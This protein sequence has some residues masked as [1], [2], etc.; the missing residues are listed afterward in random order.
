MSN[1]GSRFLIKLFELPH[2][3]YLVKMGLGC[4]NLGFVSDLSEK[5]RGFFTSMSMYDVSFV[6]P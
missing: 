6:A 1:E 3:I 4:A 5:F 2:R